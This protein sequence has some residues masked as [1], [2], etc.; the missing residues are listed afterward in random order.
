MLLIFF[1][2]HTAADLSTVYDLDP[3]RRL[4]QYSLPEESVLRIVV[5]TAVVNSQPVLSDNKPSRSYFWALMTFIAGSFPF[6]SEENV[7]DVQHCLYLVPSSAT[8]STSRPKRQ[9]EM[10][11]TQTTNLVQLPAQSSQDSSLLLADSS[12][13]L[14]PSTPGTVAANAVEGLRRRRNY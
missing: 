5:P 12:G 8:K 7:N 1:L 4:N 11:K 10:K 3:L 6:S 13:L 14:P 2:N 9:P